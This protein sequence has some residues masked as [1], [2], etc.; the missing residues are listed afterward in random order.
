MMGSC[1][2]NVV[3]VSFVTIGMMEWNDHKQFSTMVGASDSVVNVDGVPTK[4]VYYSQNRN[5]WGQR[6]V[7]SL[8]RAGRSRGARDLD[9]VKDSADLPSCIEICMI[10]NCYGSV[11]TTEE[12]VAPTTASKII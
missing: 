3:V 5:L 8:L 4:F 10:Q 11:G 2:V 9:P 7:R 1:K 6:G 12:N